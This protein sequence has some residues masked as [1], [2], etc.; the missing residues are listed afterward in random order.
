[1]WH[2]LV[3]RCY[4][5]V[6]CLH[7]KQTKCPKGLYSVC[8]FVDGFNSIQ[9]GIFSKIYII[10]ATAGKVGA[11]IWTLGICHVK[12]VSVH[13]LRLMSNG[14]S[15]PTSYQWCVLVDLTQAMTTRATATPV[16]S[17]SFWGT[18]R[19]QR[20][21]D[22]FPGEALYIWCY[23]SRGQSCTYSLCSL[24]FWVRTD[25]LLRSVSTWAVW[26]TRNYPKK[27]MYDKLDNLMNAMIVESMMI[28]SVIKAGQPNGK[29]CS[30]EKAIAATN[31]IVNSST[32]DP[33]QV[34]FTL[35]I[36]VMTPPKRQKT[37]GRTSHA[38]SAYMNGCFMKMHFK[39]QQSSLVYQF[40]CG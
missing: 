21:P 12:A 15:I 27:V 11:F 37:G 23:E 22:I 19:P 38:W 16:C 20:V 18:R 17:C 24:L 14:Y 40:R 1:M 2:L 3:G 25:T 39:E 33:Q 29:S 13:F 7:H 8:S 36:S 31:C 6:R 35:W 32:V 28:G 26:A 34:S 10:A 4:V 30:D 5:P 9:A